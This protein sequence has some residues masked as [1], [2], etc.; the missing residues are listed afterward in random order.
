MLVR[1]IW[2]GLCIGGVICGFRL[3]LLA[4]L[5]RSL[6]FVYSLACYELYETPLLFIISLINQ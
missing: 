3:A 4:F 2:D 1:S 6:I 5:S